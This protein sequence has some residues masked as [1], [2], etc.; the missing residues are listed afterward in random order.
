VY[1]GFEGR[2]CIG[3]AHRDTRNHNA[4]TIFGDEIVSLELSEQY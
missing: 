2:D 1:L 3:Y 4:R